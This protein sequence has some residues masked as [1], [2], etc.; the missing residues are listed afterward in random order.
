M[1][2]FFRS[3][4]YQFAFWLKKAQK[5]GKRRMPCVKIKIHIHSILSKKYL[6]FL[7]YLRIYVALVALTWHCHK[8][9]KQ[10]KLQRKVPRATYF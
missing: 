10:N 1:P 7:H 5:W 8:I 9:F 2:Y 4:H 3:I 6:L